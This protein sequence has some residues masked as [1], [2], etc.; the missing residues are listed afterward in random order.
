[1]TGSDTTA[2]G[3]AARIVEL[4]KTY[5]FA[6]TDKVAAFMRWDKPHPIEAGDN[7]D[8]LLL[9]HVLGETAPKAVARYTTRKGA[10]KVEKGWYRIGPYTPDSKGKTR[11]LCLDLD[12]GGH[13]DGLVNPE[14]AALLIHERCTSLGLPAYIE[15][16][17]GG[18]GGHLWIFFSE[19]LAAKDARSF[20]H[21][22][23]PR[24]QP[25]TS[26]RCADARVNR[27][28]EVFPKQNKIKKDGYGTSAGL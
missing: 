27:G 23:V 5:F 14:A 8:A 6:R 22:L 16:S 1:V 19:P 21:L 25:L 2:Q 17:G 12:G 11:W 18:K 7:L 20:A 9:A 26:G 28:I 13:A 15:R 4:L 10:T 24:D 3:R